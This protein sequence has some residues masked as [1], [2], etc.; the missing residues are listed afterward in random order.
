MTGPAASILSVLMLAA[1]L[2]AGGGAWLIAKRRD[3][4]KGLLMLLAAAVMVGNVMIWS[5]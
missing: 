3:R 5:L 4:F 1:F 2:L